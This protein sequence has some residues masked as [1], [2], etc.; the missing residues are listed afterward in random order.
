MNSAILARASSIVPDTQLLVNIV[1][2]RVRQL[3]SGYRPLI[4]VP[5][6]MGLSD[7]ALS[8]VAAGKLSSESIA[9]IASI[10]ATEVPI[11]AFPSAAT[12]KKAA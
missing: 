7:V 5:P 3:A 4:E 6:G 1:R 12:R 11:I 2:L 10:D 9:A 8:E